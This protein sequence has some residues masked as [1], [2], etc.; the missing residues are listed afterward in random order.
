MLGAL[1]GA[2]QEG[3]SERRSV[4]TCHPKAAP[5]EY[6]PVSPP[7]SAPDNANPPLSPP[8]AHASCQQIFF[9]PRN[10]RLLIRWATQE[11]TREERMSQKR[12]RG[13]KGTTA[14]TQEQRQIWQTS[15]QAEGLLG[16]ASSARARTNM[17]GFY[18][19]NV[20]L[21]W[22]KEKRREIKN[23]KNVTRDAL[24]TAQSNANLTAATPSPALSP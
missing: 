9:L 5:R 18:V 21:R 6:L 13:C 4:P 17:A 8:A 7:I 12:T 1:H 15:L 24:Q 20:L 10:A 3:S 16:R 11:T 2:E 23:N 14:A 22:S 19:F